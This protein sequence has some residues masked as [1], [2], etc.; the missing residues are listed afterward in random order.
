M[1]VHIYRIK[2]TKSYASLIL[3]YSDYC[4][5]R[6]CVFAYY[7]RRSVRPRNYLVIFGDIDPIIPVS[8]FTSSFIRPVIISL[9]FVETRDIEFDC[10]SYSMDYSFCFLSSGSDL[11]PFFK[12]NGGKDF[13]QGTLE[14]YLLG[15]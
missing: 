6:L 1:K 5:F 7:L 2:D 13:V 3:Q 9:Q 11:G 12:D 14:R 4:P 10:D 15:L 8:L